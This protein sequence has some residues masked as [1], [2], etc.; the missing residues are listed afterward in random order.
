MGLLFGRKTSDGDIVDKKRVASSEL[1]HHDIRDIAGGV[2]GSS[3]TRHEV[4]EIIEEAK[5]AGD[6]DRQKI[7][8]GIQDR[9]ASGE[10]SEGKG[11]EIAA[12]LGLK[13]KRFR[14]FE[15]MSEYQEH[16]Q[17]NERNPELDARNLAESETQ[18][19]DPKKEQPKSKS[20][21]NLINRHN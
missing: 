17:E 4:R 6:V 7:Y 16:H 15:D 20:I 10:F 9:I 2:H 11:R 13:N 19:A 3:H 18:S 8:K 5:R 21:W 1:S 14:H 12:A